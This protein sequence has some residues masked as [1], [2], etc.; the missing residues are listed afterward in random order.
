MEL[1]C[2]EDDEVDVRSEDLG[3]VRTGSKA[4][5]EEVEIAGGSENGNLLEHG[6][7]IIDD[8]KR[9]RIGVHGG[10]KE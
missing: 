6:I 10:S 8:A 2:R 7:T 5:F 1:G 9:V 4:G 3:E